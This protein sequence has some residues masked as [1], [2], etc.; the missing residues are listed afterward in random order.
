MNAQQEAAAILAHYLRQ[1]TQATGRRW[2]P[3]N[4]HDMTRLAALLADDDQETIPLYYRPI[5][6]DR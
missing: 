1:L 6:A 4:D 2:T 3:A 5:R